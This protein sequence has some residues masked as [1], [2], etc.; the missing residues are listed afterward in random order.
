MIAILPKVDFAG[1]SGS[2]S[3]FADL[4]SRFAALHSNF[5]S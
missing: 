4:K 5:L 3:G 2:E 1:G